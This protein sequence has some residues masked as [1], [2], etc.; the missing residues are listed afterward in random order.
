MCKIIFEYY[1]GDFY[2]VF[3]V[4]EVAVCNPADISL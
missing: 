1:S 4:I 3:S 2:Y